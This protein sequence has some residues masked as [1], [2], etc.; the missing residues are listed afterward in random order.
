MENGV[1]YTAPISGYSFG[2]LKEYIGYIISAVVGVT[3]I[4]II[5]KVFA[6]I[7]SKKNTKGE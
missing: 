5:F 3:I 7:N 6:K 2:N 1:N 4:L